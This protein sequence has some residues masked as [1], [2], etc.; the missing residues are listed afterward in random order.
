MTTIR[1]LI[2]TSPAKANELLA[3]LAETSE[4]AVKTRERLL[5]DLKSELEL[6]AQL[7]EEHLFPVLRKH[8]ETRELVA[9]ALN[10]NKQTRRL[11][12]E[13]EQ[14]PKGSEEFA[15]KVAELR[16]VFQQSV[17]DER[18]ELLP[19]V[20]KVLSDE[21]AQTVAG[22]IEDGKAEVEEARR[23]EAEQRRAEQRRERDQAEADEARRVEAEQ[24]H[25]E[26]KRE[27]DQAEAEE[28]RRVEA[29]QRR[30]E[31]RRERDRAEEVLAREKEAAD[32]ERNSR[33]AARQAAEQVRQAAE[34]VEENSRTV[35]RT[36]AEGAQRIAAAPLSSGSLFWDAMFGM[37]SF[38][39]GRSVARS[40]TAPASSTRQSTHEEEVIPL[41]EETLIVGKH[42]VNSGTT[43][44]HRYVVERPVEQKVA[45]YDERVVVERRRPATDAVT[46]EALTELT[47]EMIETSELPIVGKGVKVRE[48]V[49][50]RRERTRRIETVRDTV[51]RDEVEI[52][53]TKERS[54]NGRSNLAYSSK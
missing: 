12:A 26:Q 39:Q 7:E 13:L 17:R 41:A 34:V 47:V 18:K 22:K 6:S 16:K 28:A 10:D 53:N 11:L 45:L 51:R 25:A 20:L 54:A 3:R 8:K 29:E 35:I 49:V 40:A 9:Q 24:R 30:A 15:P 1:Q 44:V 31:Q 2:Q 38:P 43:T 42:T 33:A 19:A 52:S 27:R 21:E 46:G 4:N 5:A 23:V 36:A 32:R 37:W 14:T 50:V 48:E